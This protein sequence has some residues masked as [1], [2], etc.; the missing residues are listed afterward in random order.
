MLKDSSRTRDIRPEKV[1][2]SDRMDPILVDLGGF[3][4]LW[5]V[6]FFGGDFGGK[7]SVPGDSSNVPF[8]GWWSHVTLFGKG[9]VI[10]D[11]R[12]S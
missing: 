6:C 1:L 8:L 2:L 9:L 7:A 5:G 10:G 11:L 3:V 4:E 12:F